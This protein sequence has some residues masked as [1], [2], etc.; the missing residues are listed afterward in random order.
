MSSF[1]SLT[2]SGLALTCHGSLLDDPFKQPTP[3]QPE[4]RRLRFSVDLEQDDGDLPPDPSELPPP[5]PRPELNPAPKK[6]KEKAPPAMNK[7]KK[8]KKNEAAA[9]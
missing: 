1:H 4:E 9:A 5:L 2:V 7:A 6:R 3:E 8:R